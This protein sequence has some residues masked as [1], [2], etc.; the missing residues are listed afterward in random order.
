MELRKFNDTDF[1][2][3]FVRALRDV[4]DRAENGEGLQ[5]EWTAEFEEF[6]RDT[7]DHPTKTFFLRMKYFAI[8]RTLFR[9]DEGLIGL[10][11]CIL[12]PGDLVS[13]FYGSGVPHIL[14]SVGEVFQYLGECYLHDVMNG[15]SL[16]DSHKIRR[17][18]RIV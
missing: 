12:K 16:K 7:R 10:G 2:V 13:I 8:G 3:L 14:R 9:T 1:E 5:V 17:N 18:F 4:K 15:E 11:P 6:E